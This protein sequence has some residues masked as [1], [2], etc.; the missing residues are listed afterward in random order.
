MN[1]SAGATT[2]YVWRRN[3]GYV[4]ATCYRPIEGPG[5]T[6]EILLVTTN[7]PEAREAI[8]KARTNLTSPDAA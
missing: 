5:H 2:Y 6:F 8:I 1:V 3:D 7:W 4:N